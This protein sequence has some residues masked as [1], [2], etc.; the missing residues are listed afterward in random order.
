MGAHALYL[1]RMDVAHD[2]EATFNEVYDREHVPNLLA[3]RAR[4]R[5]SPLD[6]SASSG[7]TT[8]VST[9]TPAASARSRIACGSTA[10]SSISGISNASRPSE[11]AWSIRP[12]S[13][14]LQLEVQAYA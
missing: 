7:Q 11:A 2:H 14:L 9:S 10:S 3:A 8:E 4:T 5:S 13:A 12:R 6:G 1:V